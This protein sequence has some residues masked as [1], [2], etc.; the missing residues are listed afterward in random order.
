MRDI[1]EEQLKWISAGEPFVLARV[2]HTW[3]S[4]PRKTGAGMLIG[5]GMKVAGSVSGGC[6]AGCFGYS[7][8]AGIS[9][10]YLCD[11]E[12]TSCPSVNDQCSGSCDTGIICEGPEP[13]CSDGDPVS[14]NFIS[15]EGQS[16]GVGSSC[17]AGCFGYS[18]SAGLSWGYVCDGEIQGCPN[19]TDSCSGSCATGIECN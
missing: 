15:P 5:P 3:R 13:S 12:A 6:N 2:I 1:W 18:S 14:G 7:S 16:I 17:N 4:A 10:A 8:S 19:L 11:G 9:W